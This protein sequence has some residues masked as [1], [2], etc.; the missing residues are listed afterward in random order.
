M[1]LCGAAIFT[2]MA[3]TS[4]PSRV[5]DHTRVASRPSV[6]ATSAMTTSGR[7]STAESVS[8]SHY[9]PA[10][11][12]QH[13]HPVFAAASVGEESF[14]KHMVA[15]AVAGTTEHTAMFPLDT[16][17]TRMQT[18]VTPRGGGGGASGGSSA[19][20]G[21]MEAASAS[22][23]RT[24]RQILGK[25][26]VGGLYRGVAA[27]GVGAGPAHAVYFATYEYMKIVFGGNEKGQYAPLAHAA[28]GSCATV[29][30]D[31]IQVPV[32]TIKQRMQMQNSP[33]IGTIDCIK[34]TVRHQGFWALY[35]SYPTTL[36]MNVP[37]TAM[38]FTVYES[39]KIG[40][41]RWG[42]PFTSKDE[43]GLVDE[44]TFFT[45]FTAGGLA[46]GLAAA[47]TNPLDV[48]KTRM[49]TFCELS[50]CETL[51]TVKTELQPG[52]K[53]GVCAVT[54]D[55]QLCKTTT[56]PTPSLPKSP[57]GSSSLPAAFRR[58]IAEEGAGAL[59]RGLG[60]R[61]LFHIPAG[62]ISWAT[63]EAGKRVLGISG[64]GGHHH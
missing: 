34:G 9:A 22:T 53:K 10:T 28:A 16:I 15:G 23:T 2:V 33:Y 47:A 8:T 64:S 17:K 60:P 48:V 26:G 35:R 7:T 42:G 6:L 55:T 24:F 29:L 19:R 3:D 38:H 61:V 51:K 21:L 44:E 54:G 57:Y 39:A 37:F 40:L 52:S 5:T 20:V 43:N 63:Y 49:Q 32:D 30:G 18:V 11:V 45:Q 46:G 1:D 50:E 12:A 31:G 13:K 62:A 36:A 4:S 58:L 27:V 59:A 25:E 56:L 41:Q 14:Y